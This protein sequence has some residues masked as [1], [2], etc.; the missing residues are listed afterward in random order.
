MTIEQLIVLLESAEDK[1]IEVVFRVG[2]N[3]GANIVS[4]TSYWNAYENPNHTNHIDA[5][6]VLLPDN[7]NYPDATPVL[8][9]S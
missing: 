6:D 8:V 5:A 2:D 1:S 9:L 3:H 4:R 7:P